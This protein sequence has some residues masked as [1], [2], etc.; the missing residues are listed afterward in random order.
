GVAGGL[1]LEAVE[2]GLRAAPGLRDALRRDPVHAADPGAQE[3]KGQASE[4]A[5][6]CGVLSVEDL[7]D[8]GA[9]EHLTVRP[10]AALFP[11][12]GEERLERQRAFAE[13][14]IGWVEGALGTG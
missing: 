14:R 12:L 2:R 10:A 9:V 8:R 3:R 5:H 7:D 4:R 13:G 11:G 1:G 6:R